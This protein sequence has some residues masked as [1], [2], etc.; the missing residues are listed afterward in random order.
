MKSDDDR[1]KAPS[2]KIWIA[3]YR[4]LNDRRVILIVNT[5]VRI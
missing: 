2:T 3:F 5:C 4:D 1:A